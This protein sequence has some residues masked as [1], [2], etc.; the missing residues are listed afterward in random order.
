MPKPI[1]VTLTKAQQAQLKREEKLWCDCKKPDYEAH[2]FHDD[3]QCNTCY[4]H[5]Y[6]CGSC[7]KI[8]QVG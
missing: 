4:K 5:H 1:R 2:V 6:H 3:G 7:G 8:Y